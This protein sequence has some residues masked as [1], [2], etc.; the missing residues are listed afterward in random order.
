MTTM[1]MAPQTAFQFS[2]GKDSMK[3]APDCL[4]CSPWWEEVRAGYLKAYHPVAHTLYQERLKA[5]KV[6]V[7]EHIDA[8]TAEAASV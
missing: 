5:I 3:S 4:N 2:G 6:A 8:F 1:N 7:V